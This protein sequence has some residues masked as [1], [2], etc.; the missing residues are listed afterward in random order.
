MLSI[1]CLK[2]IEDFAE[3]HQEWNTLL[4]QSPVD[5]AFLTWEWL[6]TWW[7]HYGHSYQLCILVAREDNRLVGIAPLMLET[8]KVLGFKLR[9]LRNI[10]IP[11][12]D[13]GGIIVQNGREDVLKKIALWLVDNQKIWDAFLI[14]EIPS[15]GINLDA[16]MAQFTKYKFTFQVDITRHYVIPMDGDWGSYDHKLSKGLRKELHY[17][18]RRLQTKEGYHYYHKLGQ[19]A[20]TLDMETIF[21]INQNAHHVYLYRDRVEQEFHKELAELMA[22]QGWLDIYFLYIGKAPA[23]FYYGFWYNQTFEF[24][25][26]GFDGVY[27]PF[28][29]GKILLYLLIQDGFK[30]GMKYLDFLQGDETYKLDWLVNT[31]LFLQLRLVRNAPLPLVTHIYYPRLKKHLREFLSRHAS[32][33]P[34]LKRIEQLV[35]LKQNSRVDKS[36]HKHV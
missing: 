25:R 13:V 1:A 32:L 11:P 20:S 23:A 33:H 15:E 5:D 18:M 9:V 3:M 29:P 7:K 2:S 34:L 27:Y 30:Y 36:N 26:T 16:W 10:G 31:R 14:G 19:D 28:S 21:Q 6:F 4:Q 12:P 8:Q 24:W 22:A 35:N 17:N